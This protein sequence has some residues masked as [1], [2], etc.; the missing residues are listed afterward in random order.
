M[1][2]E[3]IPAIHE[4]GGMTC[5]RYVVHEHNGSIHAHGV[6]DHFHLNG[7]MVTL[8][9]FYDIS[10]RASVTD[11]I[12]NAL[13][14]PED[15]AESEASVDACFCDPD[16]IDLGA[17]S[18]QAYDNALRSLRLRH[19]AGLKPATTQMKRRT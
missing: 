17:G 8:P 14:Q 15:T 10:R 13:L 16:N 6:Q 7:M 12:E 2:E 1:A 11:T 3:E 9:H 5:N 4:H 18:E 19:H